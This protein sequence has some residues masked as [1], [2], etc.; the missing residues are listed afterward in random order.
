M[1]ELLDSPIDLGPDLVALLLD[2]RPIGWVDF[3]E[4]ID[5]PGWS[6][7]WAVDLD[8]VPVDWE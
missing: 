2:C 6:T 8:S 3:D 5:C 4:W 1:A 7:D